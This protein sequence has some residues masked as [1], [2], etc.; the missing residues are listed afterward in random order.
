[1]QSP[2]KLSLSRGQ[3]QLQFTTG[4]H[5]ESKVTNFTGTSCE[6]KEFCMVQNFQENETT[7]FKNPEYTA[8]HTISIILG[9]LKL[10]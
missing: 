2:I 5:Q 6:F 7:I 3:I 8:F 9:Q 4:S 1:M 10:Y